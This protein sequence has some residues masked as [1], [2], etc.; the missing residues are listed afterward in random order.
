MNIGL[1][2]ITFIFINYVLLCML[3]FLISYFVPLCLSLL[4]VHALH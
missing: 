4:C 3:F 1:K 2:G